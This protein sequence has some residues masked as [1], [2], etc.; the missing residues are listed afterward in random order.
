MIHSI[1][2]SYIPGI[3]VLISIL[4]FINPFQ[5]SNTFPAQIFIH[6]FRLISI[7]FLLLPSHVLPLQSSLAFAQAGLEVV[8]FFSHRISSFSTQCKTVFLRSYLFLNERKCTTPIFLHL[9]ATFYCH[10]TNF[11][12][13]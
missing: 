10:I 5:L 3:S 2:K 6:S 8:N 9:V 1:F 13:L 11:R 7:L 12:H 4:V